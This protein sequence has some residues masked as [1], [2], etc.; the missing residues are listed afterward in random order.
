MREQVLKLDEVQIEFENEP[1]ESKK[2]A[3]LDKRNNYRKALHELEKQNL[4]SLLAKMKPLEAELNQAIKSL[5]KAI[6][7]V[8]DK[9]NIISSIQSVTSIISRV[10]SIV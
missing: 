9:V 8:D 5:D 6:Q 7:T 4:N 1:D 3:F 2:Q 10:I